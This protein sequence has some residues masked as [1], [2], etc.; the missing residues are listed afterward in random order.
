MK[1][2]V[3]SPYGSDIENNT[4]RARAYIETVIQQG[5]T[6]F[7]PHLLYPQILDEKVDRELGMELGLDMLTV[8]DEVWVFGDRVTDGMR[9]EI[10]GAISQGIPVRYVGELK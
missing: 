3:C 7:A 2:F 4:K 8:M 1:I 6:P 9:Q 5:H 10:N